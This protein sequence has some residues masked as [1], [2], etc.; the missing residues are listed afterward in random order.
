MEDRIVFF[1]LETAGRDPKEHCVIQIAAVAVDA[2][3][4]DVIDEFEAKI[5]FNEARADPEALELNS[6]DPAV[7]QEEAVYVRSAVSAFTT[8][9]RHNATVTKT[10]RR[11]GEEYHVA[12]LAG[13]NVA[14]FDMPFLRRLYRR[15]F[16]PAAFLS[17]DTLQL[18]NWWRRVSAPD[19][20]NLKLAT[21]AEYFGVSSEGAHDALVDVHI[22][23]KV[24]R[25]LL[26]EMRPAQAA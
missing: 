21:L 24:A 6:Y 13:H 9:L 23:I 2:V 17:L 12:E 10:S 20:E 4:F 15:E 26:E 3:S 7:W 22:N 8:F 11:T 5:K 25:R 19:I 1:D 18:A 16:L 14:A